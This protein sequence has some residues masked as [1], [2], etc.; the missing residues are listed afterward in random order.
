MRLG[1]LYCGFSGIVGTIWDLI[2]YW[3]ESA[4]IGFA[5]AE[6]PKLVLFERVVGVTG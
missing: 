1:W 5:K 3:R 2:C 4:A 6:C